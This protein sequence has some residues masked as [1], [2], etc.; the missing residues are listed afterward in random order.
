VTGLHA[1]ASAVTGYQDRVTAGL[2]HDTLKLLE[3]H[4]IT[5]A[6]DQPCR[7]SKTL[8][9]LCHMADAVAGPTTTQQQN[10]R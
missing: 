8:E 6:D 10:H 3:Q 5:R 4:G 7:I 2:L 9:A 1:P